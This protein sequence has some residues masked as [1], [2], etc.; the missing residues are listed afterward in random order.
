MSSPPKPKDDIEVKREHLIHEGGYALTKITIPP[1]SGGFDLKTT[2][3]ARLQQIEDELNTKVFYK[4]NPVGEDNSLDNDIDMDGYDLLNTDTVY[5]DTIIV[6]GSDYEE[7]LNNIKESIEVP[8]SDT[9]LMFDSLTSAV[10]FVT[11]D[12]VIYAD[13]TPIFTASYRNQTECDILGIDYPDGGSGE[14]VVV[15]SGTGINDGGSYINA[16]TKQLKLNI[17]ESVDVK[18]FGA[19]GDGITESLSQIQAAVDA[20]TLVGSAIESVV[21]VIV[22]NGVFIVDVSVGSSTEA[23]LK[24]KNYTRLTGKGTIKAKDSSYLGGGNPPI[25]GNDQSAA[26]ATEIY[27]DDLTVDANAGNNIETFSGAIAILFGRPVG[28]SGGPGAQGVLRGAIKNII[29]KNNSFI[30]VQVKDKSSQVIIS[31]IVNNK[32]FYAVQASN[33]NQVDISTILSFNTQNNAVD[34]YGNNGEVLN[35]SSRVGLFTRGEEVVG[36]TSGTV[37]RMLQDNGLT[38]NTIQVDDVSTTFTVSAKSGAFTPGE[39]ITGSVTNRTG[40]VVADN[41]GTIVVFRTNGAFLDTET[42]TGST[43]GSTATLDSQALDTYTATETITGST[44]GATATFDSRTFSKGDFTGSVRGVHAQGCLTGVFLESVADVPVSDCVIKDAVGNGCIVNRIN[45]ITSG[46][47]ITNFTVVNAGAA[48]L[49]YNGEV[50]NNHCEVSVDGATDGVRFNGSSFNSASDC[51]LQNITNGYKFTGSGNKNTV[52]GGTVNTATLGIELTDV[53]QLDAVISNVAMAGVTT[54]LSDAGTDTRY[55]SKEDGIVV[56]VDGTTT[57][58]PNTDAGNVFITRT[59]FV[60]KNILIDIPTGSHT[61]GQRI[62]LLL[63]MDG[64]GGHT[65]TFDII[66]KLKTSPSSTA[67]RRSSYEFIWTGTF[68]EGAAEVIDF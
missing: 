37:T 54:R 8:A 46:N 35:L 3:D 66:Y 12:P 20:A 19:V 48:G 51:K 57:I 45:S 22:A 42:I 18:Q 5:A 67:N 21:N 34:I 59:D 9:K 31:N 39:T 15:P 24:L 30:A 1:V 55:I 17:T 50:T 52:D 40:I 60:D 29:V 10:I 63:K 65:V 38:E 23:T 13:N 56:D 2:V 7:L 58:V 26:G 61:P 11:A 28:P 27:V 16:G 49:L 47:R 44:S 4:T 68:W 41:G 33:S 6:D 64:V 53:R 32:G 62:T 25:I 36:G 14:Y 43:S